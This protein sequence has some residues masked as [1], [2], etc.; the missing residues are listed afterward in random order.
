[1]TWG[2]QIHVEGGREAGTSIITG[3]RPA[4]VLSNQNPHGIG[5]GSGVCFGDSGSPQLDAGTLTVISVT[6]GGNRHCN[7]H[8][9]NYR[10]DTPAAR[11][12]LGEFIALP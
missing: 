2:S 10:V 3:L 12:F 4:N 6:S 8:N 1:M 9:D 5:T 11:E 7:A